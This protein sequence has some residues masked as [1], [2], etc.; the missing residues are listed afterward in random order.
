ME[1]NKVIKFK[2]YNT[3]EQTYK[4]NADGQVEKQEWELYKDW[5]PA[6]FKVMNFSKDADI[7]P[8]EKGEFVWI[9]K[10]NDNIV[11]IF[12]SELE[13]NKIEEFFNN[14]KEMNTELITNNSSNGDEDKDSN[15]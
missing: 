7:A 12:S 9:I 6:K 13:Q 5:H 14:L 3:S 2:D 15:L 4:V 8:F 1:K 10:R 11:S